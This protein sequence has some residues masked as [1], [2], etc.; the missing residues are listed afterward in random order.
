MNPLFVFAALADVA[1]AA[2]FPQTA[3]SHYN[4]DIE[5]LPKSHS[6]AVGGTWTVPASDIENGRGKK[7]LDFHSSEK[8]LD[9]RLALGAS[10]LPVSC[11]PDDGQLLCE[12][13]FKAP[14][15][16]SYAFHLSYRSDGKAAPQLRIDPDQAFAGS[17]GD[18]WYPQLSNQGDTATLVFHTPKDFLVVAPGATKN[19]KIADESAVTEVEVASPVKLGF[20]AAPF[21]VKGSG[22]C[23]VYLLR[24]YDKAGQ[25]SDNCARTTEAL[26]H[27]WGP[28]PTRDVKLVEVDFKGILLGIGESGYILADT[29]AIRRDYQMIYWAHELSHQWWGSSAHA[30]WPSPAASLLTEGMAEFGA[31]SA[32]REIGGAEGLKDYLSDKHL[33]DSSG[34]P[35]P[36]YLLV[37]A[38][39]EDEPITAMSPGDGLR[40]HY[41]VTSKGVLVIAM[42]SREIGEDRFRQLC[43]EFLKRYANQSVSWADFETFLSAHSGKDLSWFHTQW[44]DQAGL[45]FLY[46]T[47][48]AAG[49]GVDVTLHQCGSNY[50]LDRFP[51]RI[52]SEDAGGSFSSETVLVDF[53]GPVSTV[54]LSGRKGV[55]RVNPDPDHLVPWLPGTCP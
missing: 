32:S 16:P 38:R 49:D 8:L 41:I 2:A 18:Y 9:L 13:R 22:R 54:H 50:R 30:K 20:A 12:A 34:A 55:Y 25:L 10:N 53:H 40:I 17:S 4:L 14:R 15:R 11:R 52:G 33:A 44:L 45:P 36:S 26:T 39:H 3:P 27:I 19:R 42:L 23:T 29:T 37:L 35:L 43:Q 51:L 21:V 5:L 31:L 47:W 46:A 7:T 28:F 6:L 24:E 48:A 1:A